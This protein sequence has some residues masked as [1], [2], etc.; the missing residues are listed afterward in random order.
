MIPQSALFI[1]LLFLIYFISRKIIQ[2]ILSLIDLFLP[3]QKKSLWILAVFYLPGT[4]FHEM[5]HFI[6]A[7][8][9][10]VPT[11]PLSI[12]PTFDQ[13]PKAN[14]VAVKTKLG[15]I[16]VA[17]TD[18]FRLSLIGLSPILTGLAIIYFTGEIFFPDFSS[19]LD[20]SNIP[21]NLLGV[22]ILFI[23]SSSMFSSRQDLK[24]L[25]ISLPVIV[26]IISALWFSGIRIVFGE[27][28]IEGTTNILALL[29]KYLLLTAII[30]YTVFLICATGKTVITGKK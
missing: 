5:S 21:K 28:L 6:A 19:I 15:H 4:L 12:F 7:I 20:V 26:L 13:E 17:G 18:P 3:A 1:F 16:K 2:K 10:R 29:N 27:N 24:S 30:D 11:G 25:L 14:G 22:Y 23:T 9:L 8:I